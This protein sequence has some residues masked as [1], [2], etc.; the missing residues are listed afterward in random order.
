M[1]AL[2]KRSESGSCSC[3]RGSVSRGQESLKIYFERFA[4][5]LFLSSRCTG[6]ASRAPTLLKKIFLL[7]VF[8]FCVKVVSP[9]FQISKAIS[10]HCC[11][12]S[13]PHR[14]WFGENGMCPG[15]NPPKAKCHSFPPEFCKRS[16]EF[17]FLQSHRESPH[18]APDAWLSC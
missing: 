6:Q 14:D 18:K 13:P 4:A 16:F 1:L 12:L 9:N 10:P 3:W 5:N 15:G 7:F 11:T 2:L 8:F 17:V